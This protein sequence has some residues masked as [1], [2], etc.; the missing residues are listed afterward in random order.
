VDLIGDFRENFACIDYEKGTFYVAQ[1][2]QPAGRRA[3]SPLEDPNYRHE[4]SQ[5]G[6]GY[7]TYIAPPQLDGL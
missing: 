1:N 6:S 5:L 2:S 4:R 7:Y 3:L